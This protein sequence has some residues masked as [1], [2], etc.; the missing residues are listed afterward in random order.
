MRV[1]HLNCGTIRHAG[2]RFFD[3]RRGVLRVA[4][5]VCHCLLIEGEDGLVLV[6]TGLGSTSR[7]LGGVS[8]RCGSSTRVPCST[9]RRR[10]YR[11]FGVSVS[12]QLMCVTSC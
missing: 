6:D 5:L 3:G 8:A 12:R 11:R 4:K 9:P 2:G 7:S 1:H 10:R